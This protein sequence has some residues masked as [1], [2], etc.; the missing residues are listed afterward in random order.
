MKFIAAIRPTS[1]HTASDAAQEN[2]KPAEEAVGNYDQGRSGTSDRE[3][4]ASHDGERAGRKSLVSSHRTCVEPGGPHHA[5]WS[6]QL[7]MSSQLAPGEC[8]SK[9]VYQLSKSGPA[10]VLSIDSCAYV[11]S[12]H[13]RWS[14][15][16][17][18]PTC[19]NQET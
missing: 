16:T 6:T 4:L 10:R 14:I 11:I 15:R 19:T 1:A 2:W 17:P 9:L 18:R 8:T 3:S 12:L 13:A 5:M 7:V